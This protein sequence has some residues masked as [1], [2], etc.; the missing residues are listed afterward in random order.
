MLLKKTLTHTGVLLSL[1]IL[2]VLMLF[3]WDKCFVNP[4]AKWFGSDKIPPAQSTKKLESFENDANLQKGIDT[5]DIEL[6]LNPTAKQVKVTF[7]GVTAPAEYAVKSYLLVMAKYDKDLNK[8]GSMDVKLSEEVGGQTLADN[9]LAFKKKYSGTLTAD[10]QAKII[11]LGELDDINASDVMNLFIGTPILNNKTL[12]DL[13][14]QPTQEIN[15]YFELLD[16]IYKH[17]MTRK[18]EPK[19]L[20]TIY[21]ELRDIY[22]DLPLETVPIPVGKDKNYDYLELDMDNLKAV[23]DL[24]MALANYPT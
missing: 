16:I 18:S 6:D 8:V 9:L 24:K 11:S 10:R 17:Q 5:R 20:K 2:V 15:M 3:N 23:A 7:T 14:S 1:I 4:I 22:T 12:V 13:S 21:R 19:N